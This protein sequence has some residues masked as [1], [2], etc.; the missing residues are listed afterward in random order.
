M[1]KDEEYADRPV[2]MVWEQVRGGTWVM[3]R[4]EGGAKPGRHPRP[5][6]DCKLYGSIK[7]R[8]GNHHDEDCPRRHPW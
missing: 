6:C 3:R 8:V 1:M 7:R 2:E 4:I 5:P